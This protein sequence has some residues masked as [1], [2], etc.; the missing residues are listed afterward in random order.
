ML[1][2]IKILKMQKFI[3][4]SIIIVNLLL[5]AAVFNEPADLENFINSLLFAKKKL[6]AINVS[7]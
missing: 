1:I 6:G 4:F 7:V 2:F 3:K 5:I